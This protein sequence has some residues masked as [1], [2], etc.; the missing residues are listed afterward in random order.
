MFYIGLKRVLTVEK[1]ILTD[2]QLFTLTK[3]ERNFKIE[4]VFDWN[5]M[6]IEDI[7]IINEVN[8]NDLYEKWRKNICEKRPC[9]HHD[10]IKQQKEEEKESESKSIGRQTRDQLG[11]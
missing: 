4:T 7:M 1:Q 10:K 3:K 8:L 2:S 5:E 9:Q 6:T 11:S